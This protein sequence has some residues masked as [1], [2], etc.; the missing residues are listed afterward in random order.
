MPMVTHGKKQQ[1]KLSQSTKVAIVYDRVNKWGG[2]ERVLQALHEIFPDAPLYTSI[3]DKNSTKWASGFSIT[4]SFLQ[5]LPLSKKSNEVLAPLM[6]L[7]FE[8]F[9]FTN[10]DLVISVTS[11]AAKGVITQRPTK[12][13]CMC[14]TPTRYL[15][16]GREEY[17]SNFFL[18][19]VSKPVIYY[20]L[21]WDKM[22]SSR[23]DA[24]IAIS[25]TVKRRIK[26]TYSRSSTL[27]YPPIARIFYKKSTQNRKVN[28]N[29]KPYFLVVSRLVGYKRI[30]LAILAANK[31]N[32]PLVIVGQGRKKS[33]LEKIAG[34]TVTFEG[35]ITDEKLVKRY[36]EAKALL[37]PGNE[38][39]GL[40]MIEAQACGTPVISYRKGGATEL[41][42]EGVTGEFFGDQTVESLASQMEKFDPDR[43]NRK[44]CIKNAQKFSFVK[45]KSKLISFINKEL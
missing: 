38:D 3:H 42:K 1:A 7:A 28:L 27:I 39:L 33:A 19:L 16:S 35:H 20:L 9:T 30:D 36:S 17:F 18:R 23:P 22:A 5:K 24:Y 11:E 45:F 37:F 21:H 29:K 13:I 40:T 26:S 25:K 32:V 12:H 15:Y 41:I 2:A 31:L 34:P 14:L 44:N 8:N 10:Y 43:Y 6:P 4:T